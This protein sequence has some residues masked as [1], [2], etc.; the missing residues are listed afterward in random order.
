M[1]SRLPAVDD[2]AALSSR[3]VERRHHRLDG[4]LA[5]ERSHQHGVIPGVA[6]ADPSVDLHQTIEHRVVDRL[7]H[8]QAA[9]GRAALAGG[10]DRR[11]G[12]GADRQLQVG[13]GRDDDG[14]VAA[15]LQDRPAESAADD[16]GRRD[17]PS[18]SSRSPRS[19]G[20]RRIVQHPL[21]DVVG[22]ADAEVE[23]ARA[24]VGPATSS[25]MCCTAMAVSGVSGDGFQIMV[26]P[27]TAAIMAFQ[28]QTATGK[29]NA[30]MMPIGPSG[31]HCSI[32][33]CR[34]RSLA[35]VRPYSWRDRPT[36]KSHMSI[37]SWTSPSPSVADLARLRG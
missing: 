27:Q 4:V 3:C 34:G 25:T 21:A 24:A 5:D 30:V 29:L 20:R 1:C 10:P 15:E 33:R 37:I 12:R 8:D 35:I 17:G 18:G 7:V 26:S 11:E 23:D 28:A 16:L 36:A 6:D 2:L 13:A 14:V 9:G 32:I 31:C 22:P 19:S